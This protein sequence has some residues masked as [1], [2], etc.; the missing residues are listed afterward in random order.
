MNLPG[1]S[2][3]K[4]ERNVKKLKR[5]ILLSVAGA[6]AVLLGNRLEDAVVLD[7]DSARVAR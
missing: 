5:W 3:R 2:D 6:L 7:R 4:T 1:K